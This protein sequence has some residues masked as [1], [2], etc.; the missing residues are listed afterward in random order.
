MVFKE[1]QLTS[2]SALLSST[3]PSLPYSLIAST[4][5]TIVVALKVVTP[6]LCLRKAADIVRLRSCNGLAGHDVLEPFSS[7]LASAAFF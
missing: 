1:T 4:H 6:S 5:A 2:P 7:H 3:Q